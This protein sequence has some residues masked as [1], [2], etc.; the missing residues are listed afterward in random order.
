MDAGDVLPQDTGAALWPHHPR[1]LVCAPLWLVA[2]DLQLGTA[3][4]IPMGFFAAVRHR[5]GRADGLRHIA[6]QRHAA[7]S[8]DWFLRSRLRRWATRHPRH[9][10]ATRP[11]EIPDQPRSLDR[12]DPR[13]S[14]HRGRC[15]P[16]P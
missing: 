2:L 11:G 3:L 9:R 15:I 5:P 16:T 14:V 4:D 12:T 8:L 1:A 6:L 13:R 10:P 7:T